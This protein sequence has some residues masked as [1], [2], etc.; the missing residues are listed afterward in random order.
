MMDLASLLVFA[1]VYCV[2]VALPGPGITALVARVLARGPRGSVAFILGYVLGDLVWF[3]VAASGLALIAQTMTGVFTAI[4][5]AGALYLLYLAV[6]FWRAPAYIKVDADGAGVARGA[7]HKQLFLSAFAITLG[8]PKVAIFFMAILPTVV[9]ID[10]L[11]PLAILE[12]SA[13]ISVLL[14]AILAV[15]VVLAARARRL[16]QTPGAVRIMNRCA[17]TAMAGAAAVIVTR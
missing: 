7:D 13:V 11:T 2:A 3:L 15:Y 1:G 9:D 5:L 8:N 14:A 16:F 4:K 17:G 12:L 10:A 6:Q